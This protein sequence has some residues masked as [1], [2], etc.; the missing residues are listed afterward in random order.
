MRGFYWLIEGV[1]AGCA[2]PGARLGVFPGAPA[3]IAAD[4]AWLRERS[5][6]AILSLT[7]TPLPA[8]AI[9][10]HDFAYLHLPVP[11]MTPP[12][13]DQFLAALRFLDRQRAAERPAVV[14]CLVG[15]GRTGSILAAYLIRDG[16]DVADALARVRAVCPRA[17]ENPAQERALAEFASR[18]DWIV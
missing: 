4:L 13:P 6:G 14:H 5:V 7:E 12:Q 15:Q 8:D 16:L 17:V 10:Q 11:D 2:R 1:L 9:K 18:R 3:A